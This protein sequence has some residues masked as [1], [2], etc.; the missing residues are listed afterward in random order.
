MTILL[1]KPDGD[2]GELNEAHEVD[3]QLVVWGGDTAELFELVEEALDDVALLVEV[4]IVGTLEFAISFWRDDGL[5]T[6]LGD[7]LD[8]MVGIVA[9]VG[10]GGA[11]GDPSP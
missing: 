2:N 9:L 6:G 10:D 7:P 1:F 5:G 4:Y 11:C 3:E 8:E